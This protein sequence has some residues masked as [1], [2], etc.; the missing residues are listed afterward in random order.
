MPTS[1]GFY[2]D[3]ITLDQPVARRV[4]SRKATTS[5]AWNMSAAVTVQI[6]AQGF[7]YTEDFSANSPRPL[8]TLIG[9]S[10]IEAPLIPSEKSLSYLLEK[11]AGGKITVYPVGM[12]G[13]PLSQYLVW[14]RY[15]RSAYKPDII[16]IFISAN[17]FAES[18]DT[19]GLF[20]GFHY[21]TEDV[22]G[23]ISLK[24]RPYQRS[25]ASHIASSSHLVAY[26]LNNL[27]GLSILKSILGSA[28]HKV[29][30]RDTK[31]DSADTATNTTVSSVGNTDQNRLEKG[32]K[33]ITLFFEH[34]YQ[35][36]NGNSLGKLPER[37]IFVMN[38]DTRKN[39]L[40]DLFRQRARDNGHQ[41]IEL[42][43]AFLRVSGEHGQELT[44]PQDVHWNSQGQS[45]VAD[46]VM[47]FLC[48]E[49]E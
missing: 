16:V 29:N 28:K 10:Q 21:F 27:N 13:A 15:M 6:N 12:S 22:N 38:P 20:P 37:L 31:H 43:D 7:I 26:I 14:Y 25:L 23:E 45:V 9:D 44:F 24:L 4:P 46:T 19:Y 32:R 35:N 30:E 41:L 34:I 40:S 42:S 1:Q 36:D 11:K 39:P 49:C 33:A 8:V 47:P 48:R 5:S 17:D 2:L 3:T 18:F